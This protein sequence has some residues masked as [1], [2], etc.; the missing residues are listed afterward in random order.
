YLGG[1]LDGPAR[2]AIHAT[3]RI[4]ALLCMISMS[5]L[6]ILLWRRA[7]NMA[8]LLTLVGTTQILL[9]I[10]NV[11]FHLPL[12]NAVAHNVCGALLIGCLVAINYQVKRT[13]GVKGGQAN[14]R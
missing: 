9:G 14:K 1:Q 5:A 8:L 2:I 10:S 12:F 13:K 3:H 7:R 6:A 11:Y 4:G